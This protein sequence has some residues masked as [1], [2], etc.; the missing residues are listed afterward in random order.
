[1]KPRPAI[2]RAFVRTFDSDEDQLDDDLE[3]AVELGAL[4]AQARGRGWLTASFAARVDGIRFRSPDRAEV[5]FQI[6]MNGNPMG[7]FQGSAVRRDGH[8]RVTRETI[9][10]LLANYGIRGTAPA[11]LIPGG[12]KGRPGTGPA[13]SASDIA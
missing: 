13:I 8:W 6:L 11:G 7:S 5:R 4:L 1:M 3:D 12:N 2:A 9:A 10:R